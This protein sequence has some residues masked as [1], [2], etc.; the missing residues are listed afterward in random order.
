MPRSP[1]PVTFPAVTVFAII[2]VGLVV[3][4]AVFLLTAK[5]STP[6]RGKQRDLRASESIAVWTSS[7]EQDDGRR[8][9]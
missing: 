5:S 2:G 4:V 1:S 7:S 6:T 9:D 8:R 3:C